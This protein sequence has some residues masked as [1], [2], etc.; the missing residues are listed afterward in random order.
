MPGKM[1]VVLVDDSLVIR[2]RLAAR[3]AGIPGIELSGEAGSVAQALVLIRDCK[4]EVVVVD[5][6]L[7]GGN[8][9]A[10]L[11]RVKQEAVVPVVIMLTNF[12]SIRTRQACSKL[13]S[14][15]F[16][17]K[18]TEFEQALEVLACIGSRG[19]PGSRRS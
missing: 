19:V 16:F 7:E 12:P 15:F 14:D 3:I 9:L 11:R 8:G 1:K 5:I 17:D 13:G 6:R 4:P 2:K 10:L 18:A